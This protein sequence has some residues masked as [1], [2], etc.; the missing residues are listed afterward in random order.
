M[1]FWARPF[2]VTYILFADPFLFSGLD[3]ES[4]SRHRLNIA[5]LSK[6]EHDMYLM[7]VTMASLDSNEENHR[8]K[9]RKRARAKYRF[10]VSGGAVSRNGAAVNIKNKEIIFITFKSSG[11]F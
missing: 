2:S 1:F 6:L 10:M 8:H 7:G 4:V 3:P 11:L 9:E 5:E